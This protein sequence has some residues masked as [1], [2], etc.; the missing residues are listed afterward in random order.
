MFIGLVDMGLKRNGV[1]FK[2]K[3]KDSSLLEVFRLHSDTGFL[4][5]FAEGSFPCSLTRLYLA[6]KAVF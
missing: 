3:Q 5:E 1:V 4:L 6:A 2:L